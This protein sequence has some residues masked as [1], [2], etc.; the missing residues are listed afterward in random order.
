MLN[1]AFVSIFC[2]V[3]RGSETATPAK[4]IRMK[5]MT[6]AAIASLFANSVV[7][8][9]MIVLWMSSVAEVWCANTPRVG[10]VVWAAWEVASQNLALVARTSEVFRCRSSMSFHAKLEL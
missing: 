9:E 5:M 2:S 8:K 7:P 1:S 6:T 3:A 10:K 4:M